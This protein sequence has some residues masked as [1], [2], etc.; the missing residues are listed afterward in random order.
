M[1]SMVLLYKILNYACD[2]CMF[3]I[4]F[5]GNQNHEMLI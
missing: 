3:E 5:D 4:F 2:F 1:T